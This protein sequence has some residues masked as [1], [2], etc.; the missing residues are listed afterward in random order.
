MILIFEQFTA[1]LKYS[2]LCIV[3]FYKV[4]YSHSLR[5]TSHLS[6]FI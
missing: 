5:M 2:L 1:S 6:A 4:V 3:V